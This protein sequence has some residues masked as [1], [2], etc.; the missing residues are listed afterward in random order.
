MQHSVK[1]ASSM[2]G[3]LAVVLDSGGLDLC[4]GRGC[5]LPQPG[6]PLTGAGI[7]DPHPARRGRER[8]L[9]S[10][11]EGDL[12]GR[13]SSRC[14]QSCI[15]PCPNMRAMG[16]SLSLRGM[17]RAALSIGGKNAFA[18]QLTESGLE[19]VDPQGRSRQ[20]Q[21]LPIVPGR[22]V[23]HLVLGEDLHHRLAPVLQEGR[24]RVS[25]TSSPG[26]SGVWILIAL[27][28]VQGE[29]IASGRAPRR[30]DRTAED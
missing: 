11:F 9:Q 2:V 24:T 21:T 22:A 27:Q 14:V 29:V 1:Q 19:H 20:A 3:A 8:G 6:Q 25:I 10:A 13:E 15:A 5:V 18:D 17:A 16:A 28:G 12:I 30:A 4:R 23:Q 7:T 26:A